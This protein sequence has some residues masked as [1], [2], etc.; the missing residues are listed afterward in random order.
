MD[1]PLFKLIALRDA[2]EFLDALPDKVREKV[3]YNIRKVR[4]GVQDKDL[5]KKLDED[6]WEFRTVWGGI[7]YRLFAFW[8]RDGETLVIA[9]HG[10]IKKSQKTPLREKDKA[11]AIRKEWF[12]SKNQ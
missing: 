4:Y 2:Q 8:D 11:K 7:A 9:T 5:F 6:I 3:L 12:N 1:K 10:I